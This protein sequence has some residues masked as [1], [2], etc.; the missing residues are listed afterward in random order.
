MKLLRTLTTGKRTLGWVIQT[1]TLGNMLVVRRTPRT[2]SVSTS[3]PLYNSINQSIADNEAGWSL[4]DKLIRAI[5]EEGVGLVTVWVPASG[6]VFITDAKH[7]LEAEHYKL[8]LKNKTSGDRLRCV[9]VDKFTRQVYKPTSLRIAAQK[10]SSITTHR[11]AG[12]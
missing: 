3:K 12:P 5:R 9:D 4:D 11:T 6:H 10:S 7:Y 8:V 2:I 1:D